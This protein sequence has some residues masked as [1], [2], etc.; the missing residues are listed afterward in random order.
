MIEKGIITGK[1]AKS[2]ADLMVLHPLKDPEE[3]LRENP[4]FQPIDATTQIDPLVDQVLAAHPQ[5]IRDYHAGKGRAFDFLV[6]QV[7]KLCKGKASPNIVNELLSN[8]LKKLS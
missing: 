7:M 1:I 4:D 3:I 5:S 8:K 6:G 2:I